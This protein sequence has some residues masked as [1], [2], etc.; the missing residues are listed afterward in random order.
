MR[1][2]AIGVAV[3]AVQAIDCRVGIARLGH[4]IINIAMANAI[5]PRRAMKIQGTLNAKSEKKNENLRKTLIKYY[6]R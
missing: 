1:K 3:E 6:R 4:C 2:A 5:P